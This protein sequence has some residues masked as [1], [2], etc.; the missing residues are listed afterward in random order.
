MLGAFP[1]DHREGVKDNL[2]AAR[3]P[4]DVLRIFYVVVF[5]ET[6]AAAERVRE[7]KNQQKDWFRRVE[8]FFEKVDNEPTSAKQ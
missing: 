2:Q 8:E 3:F 6:R 5:V 7:R 4:R 1:P